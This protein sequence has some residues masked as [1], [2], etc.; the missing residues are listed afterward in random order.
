[1]AEPV[2]TTGTDEPIPFLD[3][4]DLEDILVEPNPEDP[5]T[6]AEPAA[7]TPV[8]QLVEVQV[9]VPLPKEWVV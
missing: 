7:A 5:P 1:M 2:D 4:Q 8:G 3:P 6:A 9:E